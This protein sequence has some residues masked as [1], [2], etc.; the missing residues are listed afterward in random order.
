MSIKATVIATAT[1][2]VAASAFTVGSAV[3]ASAEIV[4]PCYEHCYPKKSP[5]PPKSSSTGKFVVGCIMGS[6]AGLIFASIVKGGGIKWMTQ[7]EWEDLKVKVPHP[8]TTEEAMLIA[9]TCGLYAFAIRP[10]QRAPV[11]VRAGG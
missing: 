2:V 6:A 10:A 8:L 11:V 4:I 5:S 7:K 1:A 9:G 3:P